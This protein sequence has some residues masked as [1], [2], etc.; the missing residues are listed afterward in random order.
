MAKTYIEKKNL[1]FGLDFM[2]IFGT[3][4]HEEMFRS[5]NFENSDYWELEDFTFNKSRVPK[6]LYWIGFTYK[7]HKVFSYVKGDENQEIP[8]SDAITVY[9]VAFKLMSIEE[10]R[11]FLEGYFTLRHMKR[12]DICID[13]EDSI[14]N[15]LKKFK[16]LKQKWGKIY[17]KKWFIETKYFGN[18][19]RSINK[20]SVIRVYNKIVDL[21][22]SNKSSLYMD[23]IEK[24]AVTRVELEVRAQ[25]A[26]NIIYFQLFEEETLKKIFKN[27]LRKHTRIFD[28]IAEDKM[29]L[30]RNPSE[31]ERS[32]LHRIY[33]DKMYRL[34]FIWYARKI[35]ALW[36]CPV[37]LLI[38]R[39]LI[40][41][42]TKQLFWE[43]LVNDV[44]EEE[45]LLFHIYMEW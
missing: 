3:F 35:K 21:K 18:P 31:K 8:T 32:E 17:G 1:H 39:W 41:D 33:Y 11:Y 40:L 37:R 25:L 36:V 29:T 44:A 19:K 45:A 23:Y 5:I 14:D 7:N 12:F 13:I 22:A 15:V 28:T 9:W 10:I 34:T 26:Q 6:Y 38:W 20:R 24:D 27:Y 42:E 16:P 30:Y 2:V 43:K 4:K